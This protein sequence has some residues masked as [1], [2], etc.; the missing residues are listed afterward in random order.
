MCMNNTNFFNQAPVEYFDTQNAT[1]AVR[2]Y[3]SGP[4]M[5]FIHGFPVYG[6]TW[7]Y[8]LPE[9]AKHYTCYVLDMPGLG[10]SKWTA[11]TDFHFKAQTQR[12]V[13]F[14][15]AK[16]LTTCSII[17]HNTGA[18]TARFAA[19][20]T[21]AKVEKLILINTEIP[22]HRPPWIQL[23]QVGSRL[24]FA[25]LF[26]KLALKSNVFVRS[27]MGFKA[28]YANK[29]LLKSPDYLPPYIDLATQ[30]SHHLKGVF[31]Y[32]RGCDLKYM[33]T[34]KNR[35]KDIEAKVLLI[36]GTQDVTFPVEY[37]ESMLPQFKNAH[38]FRLENG[39][40]MPQEELADR[41][42]EIVLEG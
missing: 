16:N 34:L 2:T 41:V 3:G 29:E 37:G 27:G 38:F 22:D 20:E 32:L 28:F 7:R 10:M 1:L 42:V 31:S 21:D 35:H 4:A 23:Y 8:M 12:I 6:Y 40:L 17:A 18:T 15:K 25:H 11:D 9:L 5:I 36:W 33:D 24:P 19:L 13:D 14:I 26:F 30:S 39:S